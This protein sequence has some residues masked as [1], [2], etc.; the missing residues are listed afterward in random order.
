MKRPIRPE[1]Q[2]LWSMIAATVHPMPGRKSTAPL[3][4][5][6]QGRVQDPAARLPI[7][8][9]PPPVRPA[10]SWLG[11]EGIE[12]RRKHRIAR[13]RD[14]IGARI[15]LHG[16]D[17]DRARPALDA[18]VRR[19]WDEGYRAVLVVTGKG[20]RGE[21]VLRR[22]TPEWLADPAL[23]DIVAGISEAHRRH[24]GE[25]ALYVALKRKTRS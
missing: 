24:G 2:K 7:S 13:E 1:E 18:F 17:Q 10:H 23:K 21:G 12:P 22:R 6:Q 9:I 19:A 14:P 8:E 5:P 16:Y 3:P 11:P 20:A 15:D 4:P 25:G